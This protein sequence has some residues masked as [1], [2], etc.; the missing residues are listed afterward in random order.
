MRDPAP[1]ID[2]YNYRLTPRKTFCCEVLLT[3]QC[4]LNCKSCD[5]FAPFSEPRFYNLQQYEK[6]IK[7]IYDLWGKD[8]SE[9][10]LQGGEPLL[11]PN[12]LDFILITRQTLKKARI[13][14]ISNG[15]L[16][17]NQS[18][19]F[20]ECLKSNNIV[21]GITEYPQTDIPFIQDKTNE[22]G[23]ELCTFPHPKKGYMR[24]DVLDLT[25]S[26]NP[27]ISFLNCIMVNMCLPLKD[28]YVYTCPTAACISEY[29]KKF[30]ISIPKESYGGKK[31]EKFK[32]KEEMADFFTHEIPLC[33]FCKDTVWQ[34]SWEKSQGK[35]TDYL[36]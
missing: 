31:V 1:S 17:K 6:D 3:S 33:K 34:L 22:Y 2:S 30:N 25:G 8:F 36:E 28:G 27:R 20:W 4:N 5:H 9:I 15:L 35:I 10:N 14:I 11:H 19:S 12:L 16:L 29:F 13:Q 18:T 32:T 21:L 26:Q 7:H 23:I 24:K